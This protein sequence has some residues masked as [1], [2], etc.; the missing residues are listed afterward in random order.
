MNTEPIPEWANGKPIRRPVDIGDGFHESGMVLITD[1][2]SDRL[3][4]QIHERSKLAT[5]Q[6]Q[7]S[8]EDSQTSSP[9]SGKGKT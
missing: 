6:Q 5:P 9:P 2:R 3:L 8:E 4:N 1:P 7:G